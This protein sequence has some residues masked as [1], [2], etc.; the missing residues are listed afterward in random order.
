MSI[1]DAVAKF[2]GARTVIFNVAVAIV[3]VLYGDAAVSAVQSF[4][5]STDQAVD[6]LVGL[7]AAANVALRAV[8]NTPIFKRA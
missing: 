4:G 6:A 8:S 1:A 2:K 3:G 5:L 7:W